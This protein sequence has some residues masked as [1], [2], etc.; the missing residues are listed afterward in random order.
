L[1]RPFNN[2]PERHKAYPIGKITYTTPT[3]NASRYFLVVAGAGSVGALVYKMLGSSKHRL[4]RAMYYIRS[5]QLF[6]TTRF[7][8][9]A[10]TSGE[11]TTNAV[12]VMAVRVGDLSGLF[13]P[14][15]CGASIEDA[16]LLLTI[17]SPPATLS[18]LSWF[19]LGWARLHR[20]NRYVSTQRTDS[21]TCGQGTTSRV[22]VQAD[23]EWLGRTPMTVSLIPNG[24]R[25]LVPTQR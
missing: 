22:Q 7:S 10:V 2:S 9:F 23:G 13:S 21:F 15:I 20:L 1:K 3:G 5:A 12:S 19:A 14:L 18:L 11:Q 17:V 25:L 24:V 8:S 4:G 6:L 16:Q